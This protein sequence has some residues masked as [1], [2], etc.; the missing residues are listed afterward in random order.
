MVRQQRFREDLYYRVNVLDIELPPLRRRRE[1]IPDL[2]RFFMARYSPRQMWFDA[3]ALATLLKYNFPG[4][5]RELEHMIQ[6]MT[7]LARGPVIRTAD[8]PPEVRFYK[9]A[10]TG[11]S[12]SD[13]LE[14]VEREMVMT[15]LENHQ[16]IQTQA[17]ESLGI[18]ERVMRYKM[19]KHGIQNRTG[20]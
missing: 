13:R 10:D 18:S 14:A 9:A 20:N 12:L 6:R 15:A 16:W 4:N 19:K 1:D 7:T 8:L 3:D 2:A 11:G 5:V 17:A